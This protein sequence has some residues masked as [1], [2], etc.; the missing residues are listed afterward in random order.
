MP[1]RWT[2]CPHPSCPELVDRRTGD[3]ARGHAQAKRRQAQQRTDAQRPNAKARGYGADHARFRAAVLRRDPICVID[4]C[5]QPSTDAD[6][7]PLTR[8]QLVAVG[9]NP[10][11]PKHGRGL[12]HP[13]HSSETA[14]RDGGYGNPRSTT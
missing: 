13:H 9:F 8:R 14:R 4:G 12:C 6:H 5:D 1:P 7:H 3:C 11:D 2:P 10:N